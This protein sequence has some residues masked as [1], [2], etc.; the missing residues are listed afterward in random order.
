MACWSVT[1]FTLLWKSSAFCLA[2]VPLCNRVPFLGV[3]GA[4]SSA[5]TVASEAARAAGFLVRGAM[6]DAKP[7]VWQSERDGADGEGQRASEAVYTSSEA[8]GEWRERRKEERLK[9]F[10]DHAACAACAARQRAGQDRS[11]ASA[12]PTANPAQASPVA[13]P[14]SSPVQQQPVASASQLPPAASGQPSHVACRL[15]RP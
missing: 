1:T 4:A 3:T 10:A 8:R 2:G 5:T 15:C 6:C 14:P 7:S 12:S 9:P 13:Q 11:L